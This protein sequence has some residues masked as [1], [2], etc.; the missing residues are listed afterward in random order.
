MA[1]DYDTVKNWPFPEL[2]CTYDET[3]CLLYALGVGYGHDPMDEAQ[4]RFVY[5]RDLKAVPTMPVVLG[6]PGFW[7]KN[8]ATGIDWVKILHGEQTITIHRPLATAGTVLCRTR[9]TAIVDKGRDKGAV[10]MMQRRNFDKVRGELLTTV[11]YTIFCRGDGGFGKGDEAPHPPVPVPDGP[12]DAICDLPTLPQQALIY[13]LCADRAA[14][15][16]DPEAAR[17]AGFPR[18]FLHGL[19][20]YGISGHAVLRTFCNYQPERLLGLSVRFSA[21]V[22]P[23]ET[24]RTHMWRRGGTILFL[25]LAL[26]RGVVVLNNGVASIT[27]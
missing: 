27:S 15:H 5:E 3:D 17:A 10:V 12:P 8:P 26:E 13:R 24:I 20:T 19:C 6:W 11:D 21:P 22:F 25:S 9:V 4:L 23:G 2:E 1:I 16:A 14:H 7:M 18:P